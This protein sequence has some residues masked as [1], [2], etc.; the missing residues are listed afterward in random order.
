M[1]SEFWNGRRVFVT[2]HTG[3]KG[4]WMS[5]WLYK[6][7]AIVKGYALKQN[8]YP[9]LFDLTLIEK[10]IE[11][12]IGD[13]SNL[14]F[15]TNQI[16]NFEPEIV[17][18]MAAQPLVRASYTDPVGTYMT[19]VIGT[20]NLFEA[21]RKCC[22]VKSVVNV[23]TD[24]CY[25]NKEWVWGYREDEAMGGF[26]PYSSSKGCSEL[27]TSAYRRS[28]FGPKSRVA[29]ATAR[30]GNVI[31]GGDW[32]EDRLIPDIFRA[33]NSKNKVFVRNPRATR[34][35][36]HVLEPISGYLMLAEKLYLHGDKFADAWNFGPF[37]EDV[38]TVENVL[39]YFVKN[40]PDKV[41]WEVDS[42]EQP[43]EAQ[44]LK[45]DISKAVT[46]LNWRPMWSLE[47]TFKSIINWYKAYS[48]GIDMEDITLQQIK[49]FEK[50]IRE[51]YES[52][53][54]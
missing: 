26:D 32:A 33:F 48:E 34:P 37:D 43:H 53:G 3:F 6:M 15:L 10:K 21:I 19:N 20:V 51:Y 54:N 42:N 23:T 35:W 22:S 14:E 39:N 8:T 27:V 49:D 31:G 52:T 9:S 11:S 13:I 44:L 25:E 2:G 24:K 36:Q 29:L 47:T 40:W 46:K 17:I 41:E 1:N 28:F 45:L 7:G 5:L 30:A 38:V 16:V 4:S 12:V 50:D 18:H